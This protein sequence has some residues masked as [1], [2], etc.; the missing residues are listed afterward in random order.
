VLAFSISTVVT[1]AWGITLGAFLG[2]MAVGI[3]ANL[4]A[5]WK[6]APAVLVTLQGIV[7]LVP[8][9]KV[10]VGLDSVVNGQQFVAI[11]QVGVQSFLLFMSLVAGLVF[12]SAIVEPRKSL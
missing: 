2:A 4:F 10:Y 6:N 11:D 7:V 5:R 3:Y 12:A 8:G 9:S 1:T